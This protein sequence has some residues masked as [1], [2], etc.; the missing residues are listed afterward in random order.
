M[1]LRKMDRSWRLTLWCSGP[2][3][4]VTLMLVQIV[5]LLNRVFQQAKGDWDS[6]VDLA[7]GFFSIS[8]A[9]ESQQQRAFM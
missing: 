5:Q 9:K 4:I 3:F 7:N 6:V 1:P 8:V 2:H